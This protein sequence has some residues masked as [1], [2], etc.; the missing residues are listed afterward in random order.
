MADRFTPV[1]GVYT[2]VPC[3]GAKITVT[4][5]A[6][7][8]SMRIGIE[9]ATALNEL[10][11]GKLETANMIGL[12]GNAATILRLINRDPPEA[13]VSSWQDGLKDF[14]RLR[15]RYLLYR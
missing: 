12:V 5:R 8:F 3:Q 11:P 1:S 9:I 4:D 6:E 2:G 14:E 13:I 15:A 10:Y 7:V